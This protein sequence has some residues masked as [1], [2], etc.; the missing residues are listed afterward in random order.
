MR[1]GLLV[2]AMYLMT[3]F[4]MTGCNLLYFVAPLWNLSIK[5]GSF[6]KNYG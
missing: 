4:D 1:R 5:A 6:A 2:P 3:P